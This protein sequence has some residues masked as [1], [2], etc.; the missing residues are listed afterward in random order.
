MDVPRRASS[1]YFCLRWLLIHKIRAKASAV[2]HTGM[3]FG[4]FISSVDT[5]ASFLYVPM[6]FT[7]SVD[8]LEFEGSVHSNY[9]DRAYL[10]FSSAGCML[11]LASGSLLFFSF[12][13]TR[14]RVDNTKPCHEVIDDSFP[15]WFNSISATPEFDLHISASAVSLP[16]LNTWKVEAF[17]HFHHVRLLPVKDI[18]PKLFHCCRSWNT[19]NVIGRNV[20]DALSQWGL[21]NL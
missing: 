9:Y 1:S 13:G 20:A 21:I 11:H 7:D 17:Q 4:G 18:N 2:V 10:P 12:L 16:W 19:A 6:P 3:F 15:V 5:K 14:R 8:F